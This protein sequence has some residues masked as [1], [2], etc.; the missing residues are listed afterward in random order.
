MLTFYYTYRLN[1]EFL[2][3]K[4]YEFTKFHYSYFY[5]LTNTYKFK[6][7]NSVIIKSWNKPHNLKSLDHQ[8]TQDTHLL[9]VFPS[10]YVTT[11]YVHTN[12]NVLL[13]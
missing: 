6:H 5:F 11:I 7:T 10:I 9:L 2:Q 12:F 13:T 3:V 8:N 1:N 4:V